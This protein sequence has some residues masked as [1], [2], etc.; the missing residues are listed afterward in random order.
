MTPS[1]TTRHAAAR[2]LRRAADRLDPP[3]RPYG[4]W[5]P[6][7]GTVV[8]KQPTRFGAVPLATVTVG[9]GQVRDERPP[10]GGRG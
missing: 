6:Q 9:A 8:I 4:E 5:D 2:L 7:T 3:T 1:R 10:R